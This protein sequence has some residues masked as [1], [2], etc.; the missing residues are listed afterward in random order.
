VFEMC[1]LTPKLTPADP[2]SKVSFVMPRD[3]QK[4]LTESNPIP[5]RLSNRAPE[6]QK[7]L[8]VHRADT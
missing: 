2:S 4:K 8:T 1:L 5:R 7:P 6:H 3:P